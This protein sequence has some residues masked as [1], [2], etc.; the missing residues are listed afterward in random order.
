[1]RITKERQLTNSSWIV[2]ERNE[3]DELPAD[4]A[5]LDIFGARDCG[6]ISQMRPFIHSFSEPGD[7]VLDPFAGLGTTLLA[8][9]ME[10]RDAVGIE[11]EEKRIAIIEKRLAMFPHAN[12]VV[13]HRDD[14][15]EPRPSLESA[16]DLCITSIPYFGASNEFNPSKLQGQTYSSKNYHDYLEILNA[17][18]SNI[19]KW[20]KKD[21]FAIF[22]CENLYLVEQGFIPLA[23]DTA[24]LLQQHFELCD[25]RII[26][27]ERPQ[28]QSL[29]KT[30]SN[31]SHEYAL[32]CKNKKSA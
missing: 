17:V 32:V 29:D 30:R 6:W 23:W 4:L 7:L 27:Y 9:V 28:E 24:R 2:L 10:G 22:M 1:M 20:L 31:R 16:V 13:I 12:A 5:A 26:C 11:I 19:R 15:Q 8:A 25:E 21:S 14:A 18:F 3:Y